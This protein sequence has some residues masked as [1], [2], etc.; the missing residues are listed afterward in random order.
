M[1]LRIVIIRDLH[2]PNGSL[3][4]LYGLMSELMTKIIQKI[5][6]CF[7]QAYLV[8]TINKRSLILLVEILIISN[9]WNIWIVGFSLI[10]NMIGL[11]YHNSYLRIY[12]LIYFILC[13]TH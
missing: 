12:L 11:L 2:L 9:N 3:C 13:C 1:N 8:K 10:N 5:L 4:R 6:G 7:G